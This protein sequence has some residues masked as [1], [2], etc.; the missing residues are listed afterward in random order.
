MDVRRRWMASLEDSWGPPGLLLEGAVRAD[1]ASTGAASGGAPDPAIVASVSFA[2]VTAVPRV[3]DLPFGLSGPVAEQ[4]ALVFCLTC[5]QGQPRYQA[6]RVL[7]KAL[8]HLQARGFQNVYAIGALPGSGL[9]G[10]FDG[11]GCRFSPPDFLTANG[12]Q[13][14]MESGGLVLLRSDLRGL[15]S[16]VSRVRSAI[17]RTVHD[18]PAPSPAAWSRQEAC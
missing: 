17:G 2:P 14:V 4:A 18:E 1:G 16:F 15:L 10:I 8:H 12:F 9:R 13:V 11:E 3:N 7:H 5:V 6:K